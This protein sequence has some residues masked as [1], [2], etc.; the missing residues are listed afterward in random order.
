M[1]IV[2][3]RFALTGPDMAIP[4]LWLSL[5][6]EAIEL[7]SGHPHSVYVMEHPETFG[8][9][10]EQLAPLQQQWDEEGELDFDRVILLAELNGWV[11]VSSDA[12]WLTGQHTI[13]A[14]SAAS[15]NNV[16]YG[17]RWLAQHDILADKALVE[18]DGP[19]SQSKMLSG[20]ALNRFIRLGR[21]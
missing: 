13:P 17:L 4:R 12:G 2:E 16:R 21:L 14:L 11:R 15:A 8:L 19:G 10:P 1:M 7:D 20:E 18:I 6:G 3:G 9:T 5:R